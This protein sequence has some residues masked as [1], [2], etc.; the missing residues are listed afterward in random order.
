[1]K[2]IHITAVDLWAAQP[3][4]DEIAGGESYIK[5]PHDKTYATLKAIS[6]Q[7]HYAGRLNLMRMS[8]IDAAKLVPDHSFDFV[9][10]D[11]DHSYQSCRADIEAWTPKVDDGGLLC[12]HDYEWDTVKRAVHDTGRVDLVA[13][14]NLWGRF[15]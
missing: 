4:H 2:D 12:G 1:M 11:A 15:V 13:E 8:T 10:I 5:W 6:E 9:F 3:G 14:D 7:P